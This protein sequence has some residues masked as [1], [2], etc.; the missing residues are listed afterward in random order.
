ADR[1]GL[2][3]SFLNARRLLRTAIILRPAS[4]R[5]TRSSLAASPQDQELVLEQKVVGEHSPGAASSQELNPSAQ[6][7][8]EQDQDGSH[9][10][11][12]CQPGILWQVPPLML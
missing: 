10:P 11:A 3:S 6:E 1:L 9:A 8:Y 7:V 5:E 2:S 12:P 4:G